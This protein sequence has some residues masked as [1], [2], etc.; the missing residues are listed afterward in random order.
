MIHIGFPLYDAKGTYA[1]YEAVALLS[2]L[3]NTAE[4]ITVHIIHDDSVAE[5]SKAKLKKICDDFRQ[6][7]VFHSVSPADFDGL[8]EAVRSYTIGTL[9]RLKLPEIIDAS[10]EK[11]L[12]LDADLL[13]NTDI[14]AIWDTDISN[15][16]VAACKDDGLDDDS[17]LLADGLVPADKYYNAGVVVFNLA[18]IRQDFDLFADSAKFLQEHPACLLADQDAANYFFMDNV[19]FL[20]YKYNMFTRNK[21][22][23]NLPLEDGIYHFSDD[24]C[25]P[26]QPEKFDTLYYH[27][28]YLL[29]DEEWLMQYYMNYLQAEDEAR[30]ASQA[31]IRRILQGYEKKVYWGGNSVYFSAVADVV[32]PNP[33]CDYVV[34]S[35]AELHG[36]KVQKMEVRSPQCLFSEAHGKCVIV[37]VSKGAY[38]AIK[39]EL[40]R[41]DLVENKD[42]FDGLLLLTQSKGKRMAAY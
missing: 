36:S 28:L 5:N 18:K 19:L 29:Q 22:G 26:V 38:K 11:I 3:K 39:K 21:R 16:Y 35:N 41:N 37:V 6:E 30:Q 10:I 13:I 9:F 20:A 25:N 2:L 42:F 23:K 14:K 31:F 32:T 40:E 1:K 15:Y 34:D 12:Y 7:I 24:Y 27:Y 17:V 4:K 8:T 33:V